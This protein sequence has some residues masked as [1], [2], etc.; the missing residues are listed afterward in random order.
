MTTIPAIQRFDNA[1]ASR[2][3]RAACLATLGLALALLLCGCAEMKRL[4]ME[5][6]A[7]G[8]QIQ[9]LSRER[10]QYKKAYYDLVAIREKENSDAAAERER[11]ERDMEN[12]RAE[13]NQKQN[14]LQGQVQSLEKQLREEKQQRE[15]TEQ[16]LTRQIETL[17]AAAAKTQESL[18][19][20]EQERDALKTRA[21]KA[22]SSL[23]ATSTERDQLKADS[24]RLSGELT[25]SKDTS[26]RLQTELDAAKADLASKTARADELER[27]LLRLKTQPLPALS[28][29]PSGEPAGGAAGAAA[30]SRPASD[31]AKRALAGAAVVPGVGSGAGAPAPGLPAAEAESLARELREAAGKSAVPAGNFSIESTARGVVVRLSTDWLF[32]DKSVLLNDANT[33]VLAAIA[34]VAARHAALNLQ[35]EGH[36]DNTP[37]RSLPFPDNWGVA[38]ARA[39]A[40]VRWLETDGKISGRRMIGIGRSC[41]APLSAADTP[42]A[43]RANRRVEIW[44]VPSS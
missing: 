41:Y 23:A 28:P 22:E 30:P 32:A 34:Q 21:E 12:L 4:E 35:I 13:A 25:A 38:S 31:E 18:Q 15:T 7:Q 27:E 44:F 16:D 36:T 37:V 11:L 10:D 33:S 26:A 9:A 39:E 42:E 3:M 14:Q 8:E 19:A 2:L 6:A 1:I 17:K 40:V 29:T 20:A 43:R 24:L 5:R